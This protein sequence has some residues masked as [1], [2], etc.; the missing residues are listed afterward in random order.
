MALPSENM[1]RAEKLEPRLVIPKTEK[2]EPKRKK[3]R[4]LMLLPK[5][6][7][8]RMDVELPQ[9]YCPNTLNPL[10]NLTNP[11]TERTLPT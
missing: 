6:L 2:D 11:R 10:P 1:S 3:L 8:S 7:A 4:Q 5:K 9:R